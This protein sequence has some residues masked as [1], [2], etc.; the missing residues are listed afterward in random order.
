MPVMERPPPK[1]VRPGEAPYQ[2]FVLTSLAMAI[3]AGFVLATLAP[4]SVVLDWGWGANYTAVVQAHG[5]VQILGWVGL[6]IMGMAYRLMPRFSGRPLP[7]PPFVWTSLLAL[8]A[9]L[10]LRMAAQPAG[11]GV[12]QQSALVTSGALGVIAA[13]VFAIVVVRT[14][15]HRES[16]A[17]ATGYFFLLGAGAFVAQACLN[18]VLLIQVAQRA[19]DVLYPLDTAGLLHLQFYGF[20][21]MFVLGVATRA[22]PTFSGLPRS[23]L[24]GKALAIALAGAVTVFLVA[25]LLTAKDGRS[26]ALNQVE[27]WSFAMLG[28]LFVAGAWQAGI[29]RPKANRVAAA[30]QPHVWF[31]RAAFVWLLIAAGIASYYGVRA[32]FTGT[33]ISAHGVDALRHVVGLGFASQMIIG[34]AMLIL[35]EFAIRR[36]R[37]PREWLLTLVLLLLLNMAVALRVGAAVATPQW[38]S[39]DRFWPMAIAGGLG[40]SAVVLFAAIFVWGMVHKRS[41]VE[42]GMTRRSPS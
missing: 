34:M 36:M 1:A 40:W 23:E 2:L 20:I 35:P 7:A 10:I 30:S 21:S 15:A 33:T 28:P 14:I 27:A 24:Q 5:Q 38:T 22:V 37:Y 32:G 18:L 3:G 19:G 25:A 16:R 39:L 8:S 6:F 42:S 13:V 11:E 9:S 17:G 41:I 31:I 29:L 26:G 12:W 4:L